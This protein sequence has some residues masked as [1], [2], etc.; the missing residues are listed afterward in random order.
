MNISSSILHLIIGLAGRDVNETSH[1]TS[2]IELRDL[3]VT[4]K[5]NSAICADMS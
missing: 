5:N 2:G 3:D 4:L 1:N